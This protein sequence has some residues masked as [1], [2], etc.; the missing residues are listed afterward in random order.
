MSKTSGRGL[1]C[2][3]P[4]LALWVLAACGD[5]GAPPLDAGLDAGPPTDARVIDAPALVDAPSRDAAT[6]DAAVGDA[7]EAPLCGAGECDPRTGEGCGIGGVCRLD[8]RRP[9]CVARGGMLEEG[10]PCEASM[11]CAEGLACFRIR[12][13]ARCLRVCCPDDGT[14]ADGDRCGGN[15]VLAGG[16]ETGWGRCLP[17]RPCDVLDPALACEPAEG[18]Y[19]VDDAGGTDCRDEGDGET[20]APC[21]RQEDC[22]RG[23]FCSRGV[24]EQTCVRI[25]ALGD[26]VAA[27][28]AGEGDCQVYSH[29][30]AGTGLCTPDRAR[31]R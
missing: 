15:S 26:G 11:D 17:P 4:W 28:P 29:S 8:G 22:A 23:F 31:M 9:T 13:T 24:A 19:I 1:R 21:E 12:E 5:D 14:C 16:V 10:A 6:V 7:G 2:W 18:C 3:A 20:G 27:C 30:P 25:C